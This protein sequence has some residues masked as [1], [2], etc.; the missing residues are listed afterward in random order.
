MGVFDCCAKRPTHCLMALHESS[1]WTD[2]NVAT[3]FLVLSGESRKVC[4][5]LCKPFHYRFLQDDLSGFNP[6]G[7]QVEVNHAKEEPQ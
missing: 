2:W 3:F 6:L 7:N 4:Q 5:T 1:D